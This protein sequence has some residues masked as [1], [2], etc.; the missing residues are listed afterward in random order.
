VPL[1]SGEA[2]LE[3]VRILEASSRSLK[4][5]GAPVDLAPSTATPHAA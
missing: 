2:G 3:V 4:L 1:T 5:N